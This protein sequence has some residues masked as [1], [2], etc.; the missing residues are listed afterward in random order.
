MTADG[1][2]RG[3]CRLSAFRRGLRRPATAA[4]VSASDFETFSGCR[5]A[6]RMKITST[7]ISCAMRLDIAP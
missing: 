6:T 3:G 1:R 2:P 4:S 7:I 5:W